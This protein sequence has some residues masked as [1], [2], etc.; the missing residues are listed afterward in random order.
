M[1]ESFRD[2]GYDSGNENARHEAHPGGQL[3]QAF[4]F[5]SRVNPGVHPVLP[6]LAN[7]LG[8]RVRSALFPPA[9]AFFSAARFARYARAA[10]AQ[11]CSTDDADCGVTGAL[12]W[13]QG[14]AE[15]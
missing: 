6:G 10:E 5:V 12:P 1:K 13:A 8:G 15:P 2:I 9:L 14:I 7:P 4:L 3:R 11:G